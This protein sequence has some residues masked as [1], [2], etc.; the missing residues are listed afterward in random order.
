MLI[1][2]KK[3]FRNVN[4]LEISEVNGDYYCILWLLRLK[5]NIYKVIWLFNIS[6]KIIKKGKIYI[7]IN[8]YMSKKIIVFYLVL[9]IFFCLWYN[10][11]LFD[12][13]FCISLI[14]FR[15]YGK[16]NVN[17]MFFLIGNCKRKR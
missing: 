7:M 6:I 3:Y 14:W 8:M 13:I 16:V 15:L 17:M 12:F 9:K 4:N 10:Y 2:C 11:C 1:I 5:V